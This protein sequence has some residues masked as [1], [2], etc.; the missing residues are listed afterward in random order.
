MSL[1]PKYSPPERI[2]HAILH[3]LKQNTSVCSDLYISLSA[4]VG[5]VDGRGR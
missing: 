5:R 1:P 3:I 4:F 2:I